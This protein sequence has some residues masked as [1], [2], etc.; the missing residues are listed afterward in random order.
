MN[1]RSLPWL[2]LPLQQNVVGL[3]LAIWAEI[4]LL[5]EMMR[6]CKCFPRVSKRPTI[7]YSTAEQCQHKEHYNREYYAYYIESSWYRSC[8]RHTISYVKDSR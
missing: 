3:K 4:S 1:D 7:A 8:Q 2:I 5:S 6:P